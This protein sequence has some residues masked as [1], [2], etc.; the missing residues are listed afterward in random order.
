VT[1]AFSDSTVTDAD[2]LVDSWPSQG[3]FMTVNST[4]PENQPSMA[5]ILTKGPAQVSPN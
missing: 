1:L 3:K 2:A 4:V 5:A